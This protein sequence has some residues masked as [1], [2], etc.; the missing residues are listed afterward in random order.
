MVKSINYQVPQ[1]AFDPVRV[2]GRPDAWTPADPDYAANWTFGP[3]SD[4]E[5]GNACVGIAIGCVLSLPIWLGVAV[6]FYL[7]F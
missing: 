5:Q 2:R 4:R 3:S 7:L 6:C 1:G